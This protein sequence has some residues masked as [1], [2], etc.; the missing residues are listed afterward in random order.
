MTAS[1]A[2]ALVAL[3]I[4]ASAAYSGR[5]DIL[6]INVILLGSNIAI[7]EVSRRRKWGLGQQPDPGLIIAAIDPWMLANAVGSANGTN[8]SRMGYNTW[9]QVSATNWLPKVQDKTGATV[10]Q[11]KSALHSF[12]RANIEKNFNKVYEEQMAAHGFQKHDNG[13][14]VPGPGPAWSGKSP[15]GSNGP[16]P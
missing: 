14:W 6:A 7:F 1:A 4:G 3:G 8:G 12:V 9:L 2:A 10:S 13:A 5:E 15:W 11:I 16:H